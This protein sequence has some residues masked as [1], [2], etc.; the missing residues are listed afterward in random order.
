VSKVWR[1]KEPMQTYAQAVR[2][3]NDRAD[4]GASW[5]GMDLNIE[6]SN[7]E[8]LDKC[9]VGRVSEYSSLVYLQE[10]LILEGLGVLKTSYL[11]DNMMLIYSDEE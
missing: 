1:K 4:F 7:K 6:V 10:N 11:G 5:K 3:Q 9:L 8:W 2:R